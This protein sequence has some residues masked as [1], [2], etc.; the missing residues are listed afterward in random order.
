MKLFYLERLERL[1]FFRQNVRFV[2]CATLHPR[3]F[4]HLLGFCVRLRVQRDLERGI[5]ILGIDFF[6]NQIKMSKYTYTE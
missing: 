1:C 2:P 3:T 5:Y 6:V 4:M